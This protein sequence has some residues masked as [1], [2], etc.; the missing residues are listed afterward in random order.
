MSDLA[1]MKLFVR[2]LACGSLSAAGRELGFSPAVASKR[3]ARLEGRLGARLIQRSS[4]R[5]APTEE[6]S[7]YLERCQQ[8]LADIDDAEELVSC[9][10]RQV[11]GSLH[12]SC[13]VGFGRRFIGDALVE[14]ARRWPDLRVRLCLSDSVND[15][16]ENGFDCAIRIGANA[17]SRLV[18]RKLLNNRRII[19]ASPHY[20]A[21]LGTPQ[22]PDDLR[23]HQAIILSPKLATVIEWRL[24]HKNTGQEARCHVPVRMATDNGEQAQ[25]WALASLGLIRRSLWDVAP[26]LA[27]GKLVRVLPDWE[28]DD[29]PI[30]V[31]FPSRQFLPIRT[32]LFIDFLV[33]YF[34]E[35]TEKVCGE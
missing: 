2:A 29:A 9:G 20:L 26:A 7:L 1:D 14:F 31:V 13:P 34:Q 28:G 33:E 21:R 4:R 16:V 3:L 8:I 27:E 6:G 5:L 17:D 11:K 15:L 35:H 18:T 25:D 30:H 12:V 19:C 32:R 24:T 23:Q 22:L 10:K